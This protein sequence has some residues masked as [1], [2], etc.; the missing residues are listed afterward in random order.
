M[1]FTIHRRT[2]LAGLGATVLLNQAG[3]LGALAGAPRVGTTDQSGTNWWNAPYR[4]LQTNLREIDALEDPGEIARAARDFGTSVLVT[5]I[6]GIVAFYPTSLELQYRNPYLKSD[7]AG[8]MIEAAHAE[9]LKVIGRFDLSKATQAAYAA[10]PDWFMLNRDG[11]ARTF[12]GTYQACPNGGWAQNYAFKIL[13]EA[14][15]RYPTDAYFFNMTGYPETDYANVN[16]G[17][18]T[19]L[20]CRREFRRQT[21]KELPSSDGF[22]DP[23]WI[24]YLQFQ[25]RTSQALLEKANQFIAGIH[26][27]PNLGY[28]QYDDVGRGEIQ[29]RVYRSAPEWPHLSGEQTRQAL[30]RTPG[31]PF[32]ATSAAHIDY[33]WRQ[34]NE[35]APT[36]I[37]RMTQQLGLGCGLD[38]YLMGALSDQ[39]D[40][41]WLPDVSKLYHWHSANETAYRGLQPSTRLALYSSYAASRFGGGTAHAAYRTD[42]GRGMYQILTDSRRTFGMVGDA[43]IKDG[44]TRLGGAYDA[45]I[46][47]HVEL[48]SDKEARAVDAFVEGGGLVIATGRTGGFDENGKARPTL[49]FASFP[50]SAY[51]ESMDAHG[52]TADLDDAALEF[53]QG[54]MMI[55]RDYFTPV[56]RQDAIKL[57]GLAPIQRFGPPE[58]SYP[59]PGDVAPSHP[60]ALGRQYGRGMVVQIPWLPD[61][62]YRKHGLSAHREMIDAILSRYAPAPRFMIEGAG[63]LEMFEQR[64]AD[65]GHLVHIVNYA[66][67]RDARYLD[68]PSITGIRLGIVRSPGAASPRVTCLVAKSEAVRC[69]GSDNRY[70]WFELPTIGAFEA[71]SIT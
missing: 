67:Q 6:G 35:T 32:T 62:L 54:R 7:F 50:V 41:S 60:V 38:L 12:A 34:V 10:H 45:L 14:V 2:M 8:E 23:D 19:C 61:W 58:F 24:E 39:D 57:V 11:T 56:V 43:C 22:N 71:I 5:N 63:P 17:I 30:A 49:P 21:G 46:M 64:K 68:A 47:P 16:H 65:G 9:G 27:V 25:D 44:R 69:T 37:L 66:G 48:L 15:T 13:E 1:T 40:Q 55:D 53:A 59:I 31:K 36:H 26:D 4:I 70:D 3:R 52:W 51:G 20:N 29:R 28:W 33:P 42:A 18:C